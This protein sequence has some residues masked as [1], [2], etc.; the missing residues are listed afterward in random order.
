MSPFQCKP[1]LTLLSLCGW[2][3]PCELTAQGASACVH[4]A[5]DRVPSGVLMRPVVV[6]QPRP[7]SWEMQT[8][9]LTP[10]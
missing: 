5:L 3:Y 1:S 4:T 6:H 8:D 10:A 2:P 9:Q 7:Y